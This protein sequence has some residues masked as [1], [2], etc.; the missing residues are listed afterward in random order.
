[1]NTNKRCLFFNYEILIRINLKRKKITV[2]LDDDVNKKIM[3][4]QSN[5][6]IKTRKL[7]YISQIIN[8]VLRKDLEID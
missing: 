6:F 8:D 4:L 2:M 1:M 5:E 7:I 3:E